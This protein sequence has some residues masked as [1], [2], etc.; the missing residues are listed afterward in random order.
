M[1]AS[2]PNLNPSLRAEA[3]LFTDGA[4]FDVVLVSVASRYG[5]PVLV[6]M[7]ASLRMDALASTS[8]EVAPAEA[9]VAA[10]RWPFD[11]ARAQLGQA[12]RRFA[13][14]LYRGLPPR[15]ISEAARRRA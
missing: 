14:L 8:R 7:D 12:N 13:P 1:L 2:H 9:E 15:P 10:T 5:L 6:A 3:E 11:S 4:L